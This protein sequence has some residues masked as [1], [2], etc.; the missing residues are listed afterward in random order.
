M[1]RREKSQEGRKKGRKEKMGGRGG[2]KCANPLFIALAA[3]RS[4]LLS[5][6]DTES[7]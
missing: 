7:T 4:F 1:K 5:S 6:Q 3:F 2:K